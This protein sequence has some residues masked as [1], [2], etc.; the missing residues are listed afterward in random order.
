[1]KPRSL[2]LCVAC[3]AVVYCSPSPAQQLIC[4]RAAHPPV[5]DGLVDDACWADAMLATGFSV[6]GS[7]GETRAFRQST[8]RAAWDADALY[9]HVICL[10]PDPAAITAEVT[11]R[12]G[13]TWME[14]CVE[15]FLQPRTDA[16]RHFHFVVNARG[17]VY[18]EANTTAG[19]DA[20]ATVQAAIGDQAWSVEM[21]L[22]WSELEVRAPQPGDEWGLNVARVHRPREPVEWTTWARLEKGK[23]QF[24]V[25]SMFGRLQ[26]ALEARPGRSTA[27]AVPGTLITN[28]DF[29]ELH[30]GKPGGWDLGGRSELREIAPASGSYSISNDADYSV[31]SQAL[32]IA[33]NEGDVFTVEA[34][35]KG[36]DD[37]LAGI[38]VVQEMQDGRPDDLYPFWKKEVTGD[39]RHYSGRIVVDKG[40]KRLYSIR[41]YRAN[42]QG[43]V[44]YAYVQMYAGLRGVSAVYEANNCAGREHRGLGEPWQTPSLQTYSELPGGP[45][46]ALIFIGEFQRDA[47]EFAQRL[48]LDYDL[49][50]CPTF[51]GSGRVDQVSAYDAIGILQ[52]LSRGEY[53]L[54]ILAGRPSEQSV[55]DGIARS[56]E[57]G[58]GLVAIEP[59]AGGQA[60]NPE[61]LKQLLDRLPQ[62]GDG[63]LAGDLLA[64]LGDVVNQT[65]TGSNQLRSAATGSLGNGRVA[66]LVWGEPTPGLIPFKPG[67][68]DWWEYRWAALCKAALWAAGRQPVLRVEAV[69]CDQDLT[70]RVASDQAGP[71]TVM[72]DWV[73]RFEPLGQAQVAAQSFAEGRASVNIPVPAAVRQAKGPTVARVTVSDARGR[74]FDLGACVAPGAEPR[75]ELAAV[76]GP[77][78]AQPGAT[79]IATVRGR[80]IA[81]GAVSLRCSLVDAFGRV[82]SQDQA[83]VTDEGAWERGLSLYVREP[84]SVYHRIVAE[85][86]DPGEN[87]PVIDRVACDLFVPS[88]SAGHLDEFALGV[89]YAAMRIRCPEYLEAQIIDFFRAQGIRAS[90]VNEY[91][92]RR[93]MPAFGGVVSAGLRY[94]GTSHT[95]TRC[96]SDSAEVAAMAGRVVKNIEPKRKW[97]F[98]GYN[99]DD[100]SHLHQQATVEVCDCE[101]C[102]RAFREWTRREYE[103]IARVNAEWS[104]AYTG[105]D[106]ITVPLLAEM[107]G[108]S[109]PARWVDFRLLMERV[110]ADAYAQSHQAVRESY[111]EV[112]LSFT[113]PY[114]YNS[115]SGTDFSLWVPHEDLLLRYF[116]RNVVDR[117]KSWT[118]APMVSWFGYD[119]TAAECGR[120]VWWFALNGGVIPIWWDPV[121]PWAYSAKE[122]FTPWYMLGPLWQPTER[123]IAITAAARDLERGIGKVLRTARPAQ[124]EAVIVHSQPSMHALYAEAGLRVG[125]LT[126]EGYNRYRASDDACAEA[127][128]RHGIAYRYALPDQLGTAQLAGVKLLVLPACV[129]LSDTAAADIRAFIDRGGKVIADVLPATSDEHGK[130]RDRSPLEA[131]LADPNA[132]L[133]GEYAG[134]GSIGDLAQAITDLQMEPSISWSRSDGGLPTYTELYQF[135]RDGALY[136]GIVRSHV[137]EAAQDGPVTIKLPRPR[138]LFDCRTGNY[139]GY[140]SAATL[141]VPA[142][143][144]RFIAALPYRPTSMQVHCRLE[145]DT[146]RI[147]AA[148]QGASEPAHHVL[149]LEV[150]PPG[151]EAPAPWYCRNLVADRGAVNVSMA[152]AL[153]D[154]PGQWRVRV[155]DVA[156]GLSGESEFTRADG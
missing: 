45:I 88:V 43:R 86:S 156:T 24:G 140:L 125:R 96:F 27:L 120:F 6:L 122:G 89:G 90:T 130:P 94:S 155:V 9:L 46:R 39:F 49:V 153:N 124:A 131:A 42:R 91:M 64:G 81:P 133:M 25:P 80:T 77:D 57:R 92:V 115:L 17:T 63:G 1:M 74:L 138:H 53:D 148:L 143:D 23:H 11:R 55:I 108:E 67:L 56:V 135:V 84:L 19:Y 132:F 18:D 129:A 62:P 51:R 5:I 70:V 100:E 72:V 71:A 113:N 31:A 32:D 8:A 101:H 134:P 109:N 144:A 149:R 13:E 119:S 103:T 54:I 34:V 37:A 4:G 104:T 147:D 7:G 75:V 2:L 15:V 152:L 123:S 50:Y 3:L 150:T 29:T 118:D 114:K 20:D 65:S 99:M 76:E 151:N 142:A 40:A 98:F 59:L 69:E 52:R 112:R 136:L 111:P 12:D 35:V 47:A 36:S 48:D 154:L 21:A 141:D 97:G 93:G 41:L 44:D 146:V 73:G 137:A 126:E 121:E 78:E 22:P 127:V 79:I 128:K 106:E 105:F 116:H 139:L 110:W 145:G 26:F 87:V 117:N 58:S 83:T 95:R 102:I 28:P 85:V 61:L 66:R 60:A 33:V 68:C 38:A 30:D 16:T 82:I 107:E 14:D 10:E